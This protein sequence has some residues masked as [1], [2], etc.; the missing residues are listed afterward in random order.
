MIISKEIQD[1][2]TL[3]FS[4][5]AREMNRQKKPIISLGL[6]EP[7]FSVPDSIV[8]A[9]I[10]AIQEGHDRY[11]SPLG[12]FKLRKLL[13]PQE[14][15][16]LDGC[17]SN[18]G[19]KNL[20]SY[21]KTLNKDIYGIWGIHKNRQPERFIENFKKIFKK[22]IVVKI[23]DEPNSCSAKKL[24]KIA[25]QLSLKCSTAPNIRSAIKKLSNKKEKVIVCFGSLYLVGK[26]LSLN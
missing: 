19:A 7:G 3:K 26:F 21:L 12:L 15:L 16:L 4:E 17:H 23:P 9:T 14:K 24:Q 5:L 25:S 10:K 13:C 2:P 11:S 20:A 18:V 1:S 22:I 8:K 6:G